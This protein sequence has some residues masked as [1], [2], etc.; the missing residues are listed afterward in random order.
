MG[1]RHKFKEQEYVGDSDA[2]PL[3]SSL[4]TLWSLQLQGNAL[5]G[6]VPSLAGMAS[7]TVTRLSLEGNN[8][9]SLPHD[10]LQGLPSL[11]ELVMDNVPLE[12]WSILVAV[13]DC[14]TLQKFSASNASF[15]GPFPAV[16]ASLKS[17]TIF[18]LSFNF[19]FGALII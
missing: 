12:P 1:H 5:T 10:F 9:S 16:L 6:S 11:I 14:T 2:T 3:L 8:F 13:A 4:T 18:S 7:L 19:L 15:Y 17:L